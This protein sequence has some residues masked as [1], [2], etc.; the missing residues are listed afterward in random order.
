METCALL[1]ISLMPESSVSF[2]LIRPLGAKLLVEF[3]I[4]YF[5]FRDFI[6]HFQN[7][8]LRTMV[9]NGNQEGASRFC[10]RKDNVAAAIYRRIY[11][12]CPGILNPIV[13]PYCF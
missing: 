2:F 10:S 6:L 9:D 8:I 5:F 11:K 4:Y 1:A 12:N 3:Q 13:K 7:L